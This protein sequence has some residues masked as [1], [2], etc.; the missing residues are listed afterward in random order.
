MEVPTKEQNQSSQQVAGAG[1]GGAISNNVLGFLLFLNMLVMVVMLG[2]GY[3]VVTNA[4]QKFDSIS[5]I[6]ENPAQLAGLASSAAESWILGQLNGSVPK[7]T[8]NILSTNIAGFASQMNHFSN[9]VMRAFNNN[10]QP[11]SC[12]APVTC[13]N[14]N[15]YV[16]CAN[17]QTVYCSW[18]GQ[19]INCANQTC[20]SSYV[21]SVSSM[22]SAV[23]GNLLNYKGPASTTQ[24]PA[25][26]SDGLLNVANVISWLEVQASLSDW[27]AAGRTC[28][29]VTSA[30]KQ[31]RFDGSFIGFGG[32]Q[33]IYN[34]T[35]N[36]MQ[37]VGYV[38][39]ICN[40]L[41]TLSSSQGGARR[42]ARHV[43]K[44]K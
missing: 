19:V 8:Q 3:V 25:A 15:I 43:R 18:T 35:A 7:L 9:N 29:Q 38:D 40:D 5:S 2:A 37:I 21:M 34:A 22:I 13:P 26:L 31:L 42:S 4:S 39:Q 27:A 20:I 11:T 28:K 30:V 24:S 32:N 12:Y 6:I 16:Q 14:S 23:S 17:G 1:T 41:I 10:P 36:V 33:H 44:Q